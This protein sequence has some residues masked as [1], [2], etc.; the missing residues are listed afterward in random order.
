MLGFI[1]GA[2]TFLLIGIS[3]GN[4]KY[5]EIQ[6]ALNFQISLNR[7]KSEKIKQLEKTIRKL[8]K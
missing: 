7:E 5:N 1:V 2:G 6:T 4:H 8:K 3:I